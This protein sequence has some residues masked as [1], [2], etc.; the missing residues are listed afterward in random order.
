MITLLFD[1][2]AWLSLATLTALE[3]VLG[4]DNVI[5]LAIVT[6]RLPEERRA[7]AR[8]TGLSIAILM[9]I[10]MLTAIAWILSLTKIGRAHV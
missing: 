8:N 9:R 5:F 2:N 3:I 1:P 10:A 6:S 4:I 7:P